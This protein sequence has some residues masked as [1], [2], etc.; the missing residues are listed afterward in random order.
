[1]TLLLYVTAGRI[2]KEEILSCFDLGK[3]EFTN[4]SD[5][6]SEYKQKNYVF[7]GSMFDLH[8]PMKKLTQLYEGRVCWA[9]ITNGPRP[10]LVSTDGL[11]RHRLKMGANGA[12]NPGV[13]KCQ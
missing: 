13:A 4:N 5:Q 3:V 8:E 9:L 7:E 12:T 2:E 10:S 1:M 6:E 11:V